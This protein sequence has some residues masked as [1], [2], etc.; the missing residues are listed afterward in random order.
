MTQYCADRNKSS[1]GD[2]E[3]HEISCA[4]VPQAKDRLE[5]GNHPDCRSAVTAAKRVYAQSTGC[6]VCSPNCYSH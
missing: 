4:Y 1:H 5:L 2:H 6:S 3:V